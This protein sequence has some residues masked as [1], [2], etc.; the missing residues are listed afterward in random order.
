M[1]KEKLRKNKIK[2]HIIS[3]L[4]IFAL[5]TSTGLAK[6]S[7]RACRCKVTF[8]AWGRKYNTTETSEAAKM[9][10]RQF[11]SGGEFDNI[12]MA[13]VY[14]G[15]CDRL[16]NCDRW[17]AWFNAYRLCSNGAAYSCSVGGRNSS[18]RFEVACSDCESRHCNGLC[19]L[20]CNIR[21]F[22]EP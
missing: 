4:A 3:R 17:Q 22:I 18:P 10:V 2:M 15:D 12:T 8:R 19:N 14:G 13:T 20:D 6:N 7:C 16:G 11:I 9:W 21:P 1:R 5:I